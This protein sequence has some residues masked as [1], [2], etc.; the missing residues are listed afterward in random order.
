MLA[1]RRTVGNKANPRAINLPG[2]RLTTSGLEIK[3]A[4][5]ILVRGTGFD[6]L[7]PE[8]V[9]EPDISGF[10]TFSD[11]NFRMRRQNEAAGRRT[12]RVGEEG[13]QTR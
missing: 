2:R 13:Q 9:V 4:F 11:G 1:S 7:P 8:A 5:A 12:L 3:G 6:L 10:T